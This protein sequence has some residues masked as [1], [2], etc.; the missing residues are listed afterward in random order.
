MESPSNKKHILIVDDD[1]EMRSLLRACLEQDSY[2]VSEAE[3]GAELN[4]R[5]DDDIDLITL[6][7]MLHGEDGL[8]L[9]RNIR[10]N[11]RVPIIMVTSRGD[12][13]DRVI[14]L[15]LGADDYITKPF[16]VRELLARV[17]SVL[18]RTHP[19]NE[20][21]Q[22]EDQPH[23]QCLKFDDWIMDP[24]KLELTTV[25]GRSR[26]ITSGQFDLLEVFATNPHIVLS[27][28]RI[29]DLLKGVDWTPT[30]RSIDNRIAQLRRVI[31][32]DPK[33]PKLIKTVHG[34][35]YKFTADVIVE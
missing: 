2:L 24:R 34:R 17:R 22:T 35:G 31:E 21:Q 25:G 33:N 16:H 7:L 10:A 5:L 23:T 29:M 6:D 12:E 11:S 18:R 32:A 4:Q 20:P 1:P 26:S 15:E 28:D 3:S 19:D 8:T 30:D 9:A 13:V 14:G 27:R